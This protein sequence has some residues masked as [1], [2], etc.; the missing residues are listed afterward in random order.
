MNR[1]QKTQQQLAES[2]PDAVLQDQQLQQHL[3][4]CP[5]CSELL[6]A[7]Q[8]LD[9]ELTGMPE[10]D[11]PD[12]LVANTLQAVRQA[13]PAAQMSG[14]DRNRLRWAS[15][16]AAV[17]VAVS[18]AGLWQAGWREMVLQRDYLTDPFSS[19]A[20]A[21]ASDPDRLNEYEE[22]QAPDDHSS[23]GQ[24]N[25]RAEIIE[26]QRKRELNSRIQNKSARQAEPAAAPPELPAAGE[27]AFPGG[28][29][30]TNPT[31][32]IPMPARSVPTGLQRVDTTGSRVSQVDPKSPRQ[33]SYIPLQDSSELRGNDKDQQ[34]AYQQNL[35]EQLLNSQTLPRDELKALAKTIADGRL[36]TEQPSPGDNPPAELVRIATTGGSLSAGESA[37]YRAQEKRQRDQQALDYH[38]TEQTGGL[39]PAEIESVIPQSPAE[40]VAEARF[41]NKQRNPTTGSGKADQAPGQEIRRS[42]PVDQAQQF[43]NQL[44]S[45]DGLSYQSASG[46]WAN[47][48]VPGD[49][50]IA[51]LQSQLKQRETNVSI[52]HSRLQ[53]LAQPIWQPFDM[54]AE[55]ALATYLHSD[56]SHIDGP[57]RLRLQVGLQTSEHRGGQRPAMNLAVVLDLQDATRT[58]FSTEIRALLDAL[59]A[60]RQTG[61]RFSLTIAGQ[62]GGV[63]IPAG[64]FRHGTVAVAVNQMFDDAAPASSDTLSLP[65]AITA[66]GQDLISADSAD[67]VLGTNLMLLV[68]ATTWY[69]FEDLLQLKQLVHQNAVNGLLLSAVSLGS[70]SNVQIINDL[71]LAGQGQRRS[72]PNADAA[73]SVI[74]EELY[75]A[76]RAVARAVR[77]RIQLAPG[78]KLVEVHGSRRLDTD[79]AQRVRQAENSIDQRLAD[80][81]GIAVDRGE[82]EAGIQIV[83]PAMPAGSRHVV[84][85]DVVA[86]QP[87]PI[88]DVQVRYKDLIHLRNAVARARLNLADQPRSAGKLELNV[89][90]NLL[91]LELAE[92]LSNTSQSLVEQDIQA[93]KRQLSNAHELLSGLRQQ[94][95]ELAVDA[96]LIRDEQLL[97]EY[98]RMLN[99]D[100]INQYVNQRYLADAL[101]LAAFHKLTG[102][103]E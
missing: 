68:T 44:D 10:L 58:Q 19:T 6:E 90:K 92:T 48:Y 42:P 81:L 102:P 8:Q 23:I 89:I 9:A 77:L 62:P 7:L 82:D 3:D 55:A 4:H 75:T 33:S 20:S 11:A 70:K 13:E 17:F 5:Q 59:Q 60:A 27:I 103:L 101:Q 14:F 95:P 45:L 66:A 25:R 24:S 71:V 72:L 100:D 76:S 50:V 96:D 53:Q 52:D 31:D 2:G 22:E 91:A 64:E 80:N 38:L 99:L 30:D 39:E 34:Q 97:A 16:F 74:E 84:L 88:A 73:K 67:S 98:Q 29:S 18:V 51:F 65:Q 86:E 1:C 49:P 57:T 35:R 36:P 15:G 26:N 28:A 79:Q 46:Y 43:L 87:G 41:A 56:K 21:P 12:Q 69:S 94:V 47:N 63:L 54:P 37:E 40:P 85:L 83:I 93:A 78:V 61:D 32:N